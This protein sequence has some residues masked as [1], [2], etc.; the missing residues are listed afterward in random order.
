MHQKTKDNIEKIKKAIEGDAVTV[1]EIFEKTNVTEANIYRYSSLGYIHLPYKGGLTQFHRGKIPEKKELIHMLLFDEGRTYEDVGERVGL[2]RESIRSYVKKR[3]YKERHEEAKKRRK[4]IKPNLEN[5]IIKFTIKKGYDE[6]VGEAVEY[7]FDKKRRNR[8]RLLLKNL[9][10][11]VKVYKQAEKDGRKLSYKELAE[12]SG[13]K[14]TSTVGT[15]LKGMGLKSFYWNVNEPF[16]RNKEM[17][18]KK[19]NKAIAEGAETA[20]EI[21]EKS[22]VPYGSVTYYRDKGYIKMPKKTRKRKYNKTKENLE[23]ISI[24]MDEGAKTAKEISEK[25]GVSYK[26]VKYYRREGYIKVPK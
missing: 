15:A 19:I 14:N 7:Y 16:P 2:S 8:S 18:I 9:I 20:G 23:L 4:A 3:G 26:N 5:A 13:I 10:E 1:S 6:C 25:S 11:L 17:K 22:G 12:L 24:V 21:S